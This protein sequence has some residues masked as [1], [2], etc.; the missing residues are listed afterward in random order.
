MAQHD[1]VDD[2]IYIYIYIGILSIDFVCDFYVLINALI[3]W[4]V[5]RIN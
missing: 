4:A 3:I 5:N 1:D 2:Y